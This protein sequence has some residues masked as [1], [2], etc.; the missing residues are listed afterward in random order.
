MS[1][2]LVVSDPQ[3]QDGFIKTSGKCKNDNMNIKPV[4][5]K[6]LVSKDCKD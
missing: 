4:P 1:K 5:I 3:K 6:V 2:D